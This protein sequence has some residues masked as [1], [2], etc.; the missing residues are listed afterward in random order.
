[1]SPDDLQRT[2]KWARQEGW[3][4]GDGD[5]KVFFNADEKGFFMGKT[6]DGE[7]VVS[8]LGVRYSEDYGFVGLY[9]CVPEHRGKGYGKFTF[10]YVIRHLEGKVVGLDGVTAQPR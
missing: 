7:H 4:P 3:N 2:M 6:T 8:V 10:G 9:I 5:A 1:M